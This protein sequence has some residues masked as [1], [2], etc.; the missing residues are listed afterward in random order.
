MHG[1]YFNLV[2]ILCIGAIALITLGLMV[3]ARTAS[4]ELAGGL[5]NLFTWPM[6]VMSGVWFSLEG[7]HPFVKAIAQVL[8]LTH[9][10]DASRAIMIDGATLFDIRWHIIF[11][12]VFTV[13]CAVIS[14]RLFRWE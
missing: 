5:L 2:F 12:V 9:I 11:L 4:E 1:S 7:A 3:A 14:A 13:L 8:P 10:V 6:I